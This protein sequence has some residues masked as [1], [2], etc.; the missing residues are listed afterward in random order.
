MVGERLRADASRSIHVSRKGTLTGCDIV[1]AD[2]A[3]AGTNLIGGSVVHRV[4]GWSDTKSAQ[5]EAVASIG[6]GFPEA[7]AVG[8]DGVVYRFSDTGGAPSLMTKHKCE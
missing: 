7:M 5:I 1:D 4:R 2:L 3:W 6:P 8:P